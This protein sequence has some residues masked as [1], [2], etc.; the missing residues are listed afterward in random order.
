RFSRQEKAIQVGAKPQFLQ[1]V[2]AF[3][4]ARQ[5]LCSGNRLFGQRVQRSGSRPLPALFHSELSHSLVSMAQWLTATGLV[6][7]AGVG[8][9]LGALGP[10]R[11]AEN[12]T[13]V[14]TRLTGR[15]KWKSLL[16]SYYCEFVL[17]WPRLRVFCCSPAF[18][19]RLRR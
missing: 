2:G 6:W 5:I 1:G 16:G 10:R 14:Y 8:R 19:Q 13:R 18:R 17:C 4:G 3:P 11:R 12:P 9:R 7:A 15:P